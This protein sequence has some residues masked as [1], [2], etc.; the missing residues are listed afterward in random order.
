MTVESSWND[1]EFDSDDFNELE[2]SVKSIRFKTKPTANQEVDWERKRARLDL[3]SNF[4]KSF[5]EKH[6]ALSF[7][8]PSGSQYIDPLDLHGNDKYEMF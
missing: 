2:A 7:V 5:I 8:M 3:S 6:S 4:F 1:E